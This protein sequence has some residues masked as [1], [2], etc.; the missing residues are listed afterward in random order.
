MENAP[1]SNP[2]FWLFMTA[3]ITFWSALF[4]FAL[5][6]A[7]QSVRSRIGNQ[8]GGASRNDAPPIERVQLRHKAPALESFEDAPPAWSVLA[9][10]DDRAKGNDLAVMPLKQRGHTLLA[11]ESG[12]GKTQTQLRLMVE[13][14]RSGAQCYWLSEHSTLYNPHDQVTDLRPIASRFA[15]TRNPG[16]IAQT[17]D[18]LLVSADSELQTRKDLYDEDYDALERLPIVSIHLGEWPELYTILNRNNK[19]GDKVAQALGA[20]IRAG[21]KYRMFIGSLDMQDGR[22]KHGLDTSDLQ[23]MWTKIVGGVDA[24]SWRNLGLDGRPPNLAKREWFVSYRNDAG[25]RRTS[26]ARFELASPEMIASIA[27]GSTP[28]APRDTL[29]I[30]DESELVAGWLTGKPDIAAREVARRL[31]RVRN[32]LA[33]DAPIDYDG[34][35]DLFYVARAMLED[36]KRGVMS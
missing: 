7:G 23:Q 28:V 35:G 36:V 18:R 32:N 20:L 21:R 31:Y 5:M 10:K 12:W 14:M 3:F 26:T 34:T 22:A 2:Q 4:V 27:H 25:E 6:K 29:P 33:P 15:R 24:Q 8:T 30:V 9:R 16:E 19:A 13:D 17:L 1:T 11:A